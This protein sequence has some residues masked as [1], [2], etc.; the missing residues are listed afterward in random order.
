[1]PTTHATSNDPAAA[2][3]GETHAA[4]L[5]AS[6]CAS[7]GLDQTA[8]LRQLAALPAVDWNKLIRTAADH[9][10]LPLLHRALERSAADLVPPPARALLQQRAQDNA[11]RNLMLLRSLLK[12]IAAMRNASVRVLPYKGPLLAMAAYGDP[13]LRQCSDLDII[14]PEADLPAARAALEAAG[15]RMADVLDNPDDPLA[16]VNAH[17]YHLTYENHDRSVSVELHW[18][19]VGKLFSFRLD[20]VDLW[21]GS[22]TRATAGMQ[23]HALNAEDE[24][25]VL[26]VHGTKHYWT[27]LTWICDIA[28]Y[29]R[30]NP[31]MDWKRLLERSAAQDARGML[32]VALLL[33][34][35][36]LGIALPAEIVAAAKPGHRAAATDLARRLFQ[37][38]SQQTDAPLGSKMQLS[39]GGLLE[40]LLF[41]VRTRDRWSSGIR[42]CFHRAFTPTAVDVGH[43]KLPRPLRFMYY[44]VRPLRLLGKY[45]PWARSAASPTPARSN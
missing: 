2:A 45:G 6:A 18:D 11:R 38:S 28:Q 9:G 13:S 1:M 37:A 40:S 20:P 7:L 26:C 4:L 3:A 44:L 5:L 12:L 34:S 36:V 16:C 10:T 15:F 19:V 32:I 35:E 25:L 30:Q 14:V 42:Y 8:K 23:V 31:A 33:A 24:L 29:L 21:S 27:R 39:E 41:H 43:T 22:T 17:E